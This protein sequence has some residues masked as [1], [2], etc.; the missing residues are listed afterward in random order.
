MG[1]NFSMFQTAAKTP[2]QAMR[3][4]SARIE[5]SA[6]EDGHSYSGEIGMASGVVMTTKKFTN[7]DTA[8]DWL[9]DNAEKWGPALGVTL[10][11]AKK[12]N[13]LRGFIFGAWCSS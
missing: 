4:C 13:A 11:S 5:Q 8:I 3:D 10:L 2:E 9:D 12:G 7:P 1:A 6:Y